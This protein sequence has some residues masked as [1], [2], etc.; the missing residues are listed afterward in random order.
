M[1]RLDQES[2]VIRLAAD[3]GLG[4]H[5]NPVAAIVAHCL[6]RMAAWLSEG[7]PPDGVQGIQ[8]IVCRRLGLLFEPIHDDDGLDRVIRKYIAL[9]DPVFAH[10]ERAIAVIRAAEKE[11]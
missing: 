8:D 6:D 9:G 4:Q 3:L 5:G 10:A 7:P 2:E 11:T 1:R